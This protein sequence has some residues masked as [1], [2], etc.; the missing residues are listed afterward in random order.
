MTLHPI[1][2][3]AFTFA[4]GLTMHSCEPAHAQTDDGLLLARVMVNEA[5][6]DGSADHL[7]IASYTRGLARRWQMPIGAAMVRR[8][9]RALAPASQRRDRP[10][11][12]TLTR[13]DAAP[14]GWREERQPWAERR[15]Q[16]AATLA[17]ADAFLAGEI[18]AP[19]GCRPQS[20]GG[21][22]DQARIDRILARGGR[23]IAC[24]DT[25]NVFLRFGGE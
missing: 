7:A 21:S 17:R 1:H 5:G 8:Y 13:G 6:F 10:W 16:W 20:W 2:L 22:M 3:A 14:V 11:I 12:A 24:G 9:T 25:K 4:V 18:D 19:D 15:E 23:V